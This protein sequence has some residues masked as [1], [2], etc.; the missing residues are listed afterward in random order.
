M[1][2]VKVEIVPPPQIEKVVV[3]TM[4][5]KHARALKKVLGRIC[6]SNYSARKLTEEIYN[7]LDNVDLGESKHVPSLGSFDIG[8]W[9]QSDV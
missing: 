6:G 9:D 4:T 1:S 5:T 2:Q 3:I 8:C 7:E